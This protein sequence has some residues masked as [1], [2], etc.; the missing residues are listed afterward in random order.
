[1]IEFTVQRRPGT[2][3]R[4]RIAKGLSRQSESAWHWNAYGG[5]LAIHLAEAGVLPADQRHVANAEFA[6]P[7][8]VMHRSHDHLRKLASRCGVS[9]RTSPKQCQR[10]PCS[11]T[12]AGYRKP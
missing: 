1:M 8:H 6:E 9:A 3:A 7:A 5:E 11:I 2:C 12:R 4:E 10:M